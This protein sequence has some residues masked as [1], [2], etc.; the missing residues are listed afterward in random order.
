MLILSISGLLTHKTSLKLLKP[1]R[2]VSSYCIP[3][4]NLLKGWIVTHVRF[5]YYDL[6]F[7][8]CLTFFFEVMSG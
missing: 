4:E 7:H 1:G 6:I 3:H 5:M 2:F 8:Q